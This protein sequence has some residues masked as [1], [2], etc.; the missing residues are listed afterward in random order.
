MSLTWP[1]ASGAVRVQRWWTAQPCRELNRCGAIGAATAPQLSCRRTEALKTVAWRQQPRSLHRF[2]YN[3][4]QL[5]PFAFA[6]CHERTPAI[7]EC[8]AVCGAA[9]RVEDGGL[10]VS[11]KTSDQNRVRGRELRQGTYN[12]NTTQRRIALLTGASLATLGLVT[13]AF[14]QAAP[15]DAAADGI[16]AGTSVAD[17]TAPFTDTITICNIATASPECFLGVKNSGAANETSTVNSAATGQ[18]RVYANPATGPANLTVTN[19][20]GST[21][22]IGAVAIATGAGAT[23]RAYNTSAISMYAYGTDDVT[24]AA[25]N[26]GSLLLDAFASA[27]ASTGAAYAY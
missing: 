12:M 14:A 26:G 11:G 10:G 22:E 23:A 27:N 18:V 13:P 20:A 15:H 1:L 2:L 21:A 4:N 25:N 3:L 8:L 17:T 24:L 16:Y 5:S 9:S 6:H 7:R 19:A